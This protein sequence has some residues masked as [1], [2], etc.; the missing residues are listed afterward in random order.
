MVGRDKRLRGHSQRYGTCHRC[1]WKGSV[2]R[3][4]R[5]DRKLLNIGHDYGR[6]CEECIHDLLGP[7]VEQNEREKAG[8]R[9]SVRNRHV[10]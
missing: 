3:V 9:R 5:R 10:A 4:K 6:M 7:Q 1:G 8:K 2:A